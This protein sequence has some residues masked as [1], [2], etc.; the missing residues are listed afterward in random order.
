MLQAQLVAAASH[1]QS[2]VC[3]ARCALRF[4]GIRDMG[5]YALPEA[6][7]EARLSAAAPLAEGADQPGTTA[8]TER[9]IV[10]DQKEERGEA[11]QLVDGV[12]AGMPQLADVT[13]D[14]LS[15]APSCPLCV[16]CLEACV[17]TE[18]IEELVQHVRGEGYQMKSFAISVSLP[19]SLLVRQRAGWLH[20]DKRHSEVAA[21]GT[22]TKVVPS[23]PMLKTRAQC[24][25]RS[26]SRSPIFPIHA[27][28]SAA[29]TGGLS[30]VQPRR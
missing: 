4:A 26:Q 29:A 10:E 8:A 18:S 6:D 30:P 19:V 12:A 28:L 7:I 13:T 9:M 16:G 5:I 15:A 25:N 23:L 21:E 14:Q 3:C 11:V 22:A 20:L 17:Q 1:K 27:N 24:Q 2:L